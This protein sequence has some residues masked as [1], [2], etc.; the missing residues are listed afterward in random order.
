MYL[1]LLIVLILIVLGAFG[2]GYT[3]RWP[4][5]YAYGG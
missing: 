4:S 5:H 1:V 3:G 2:G